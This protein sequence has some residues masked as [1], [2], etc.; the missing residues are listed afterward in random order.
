MADRL[1]FAVVGG[2]WISQAAFIPGVGQTD[3]AA[4][5]ALVTGD[6]EKAAEL[7][8]RYGVKTATYD[9][10]EALLDSGEIDAVYVA[11]PT[12]RHRQDAIPALERGIPV[13]LEKPMASSLADAEAIEAAAKKSGAKLMIAYRLHF[14]PGTLDLIARVRDGEL[15]DVHLFSAVFTQHVSDDNHRVKSGFWPGPVP[16]MGTYPINAVRNIFGA[17]PIEVSAVGVRTRPFDLHDIVSVTLRFPGERLAQFV[18]SFTGG[19][20]NQYRVVGTKGEITADPAFMFGPGTSIRQL[21]TIG[22]KKDERHFPITDQFGGQ[23][24]YFVECVRNNQEPEP[25]GEE[26]IL[27]MIVLEAIERALTTGQTQ[28]LPERNRARRPT[29]DQARTLPLAEVPAM[30]NAADPGS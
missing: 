22:G 23:T 9:G 18:V 19:G 16:D 24:D 8:R 30:V 11:T 29:Q 27:D 20:I 2:G 21:S 15:G 12:F 10:Y 28:M 13:L 17:E 26:G 4:F 6:P 25:N 7:G 14:E 1:R 5:T 3:N